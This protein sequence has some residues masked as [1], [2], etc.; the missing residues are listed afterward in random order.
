MLRDPGAKPSVTTG[1]RWQSDD[2]KDNIYVVANS[3][4]E[5]DWGYNNLQW[6][7]VTLY[8]SSIRNGTCRSRST[9]STR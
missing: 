9:S 8:H 6:Y 7:G 1:I 3:M 2:A 5:G 4:N